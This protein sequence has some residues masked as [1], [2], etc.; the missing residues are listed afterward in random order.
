MAKK[1]VTKVDKKK[2]MDLLDLRNGA[3]ALIKVNGEIE[4]SKFVSW[5]NTNGQRGVIKTSYLTLTIRDKN[6]KEGRFPIGYNEASHNIWI[7]KE[8]AKRQEK[9]GAQEVEL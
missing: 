7:G 3:K 6:G 2:T 8:I 5:D 1:E 4:I 9:A